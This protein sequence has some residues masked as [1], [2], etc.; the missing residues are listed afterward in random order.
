VRKLACI[1]AVAIVALLAL[2]AL[3]HKRNKRGFGRGASIAVA[4]GG[5]GDSGPQY[6]AR[7]GDDA[8]T[9]YWQAPDEAAWTL[10][11]PVTV[12]AHVWLDATSPSN[13]AVSTWGS[14]P[15]DWSW[16]YETATCVGAACP[17]RFRTAIAASDDGSGC[18]ATGTALTAITAGEW[19]TVCVVSDPSTDVTTFY[20]DG[21]GTS[22]VG[23]N[24]GTCALASFRDSA[25]L[26]HVG[27]WHTLGRYWRGYIRTVSVWDEAL[28]TTELDCVHSTAPSGSVG[29]CADTTPLL[30]VTGSATAHTTWTVN[31]A[32]S[33][34]DLSGVLY[35]QADFCVEYP[36]LAAGTCPAPTIDAVVLTGP[37]YFH[38][39][40]GSAQAVVW[41]DAG[42]KNDAGF[43][44]AYQTLDGGVVSAVDNSVGAAASIGAIQVAASSTGRPFILVDWQQPQ[45]ATWETDVAA[46]QT[47]LTAAAE[48]AR[49]RGLLLCPVG[50]WDVTGGYYQGSAGLPFLDGGTSYAPDAGSYLEILR[51]ITDT[52][53]AQIAG[54]TDGGGVD[55]A[56]ASLVLYDLKGP[57]PGTTTALVQAPYSADFY[58]YTTT[59]PLLDT[60]GW[61]VQSDGLHFDRV[62]HQQ[63]ADGLARTWVRASADTTAT[64]FVPT[65]ATVVDGETVAV[66]FS[67]PC[68]SHGDCATD[69]PLSVDVAGRVPQQTQGGVVSHGLHFWYGGSLAAPPNA[70]ATATPQACASP[71][72]SCTVNYV[73]TGGLP[74]FDELSFGDVY[75]KVF[76][77]SDCS[78]GPAAIYSG[79]SNLVSRVT[80]ACKTLPDGGTD[81]YEQPGYNRLSATY[82]A[83]VPVDAGFAASN[84]QYLAA[85]SGNY[86]TAANQGGGTA[87]CI[88]AWGD[89]PTANLDTIV[90][91]NT[92]QRGFVG[93][94]GGTWGCAI[95]GSGTPTYRVAS[96]T[97]STG[98]RY[99]VACCYAG[100]GAGPTGIGVFVGGADVSSTTNGSA[101]ALEADGL[102]NFPDSAATTDVDEVVV[103]PGKT[104]LTAGELL[105]LRCAT[106]AATDS[107]PTA[108]ECTGV[109]T[110]ISAI[111]A[112]AT[113]TRWYG[114]EGDATDRCGVLNGSA[115]GT[116]PY[117][118][119]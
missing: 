83:G 21:S 72:T 103:M 39:G 36:G 58:D 108:G 14:Y 57:Y 107:S 52:L 81:C 113:G 2:G 74:S 29:G 97:Y 3:P 40:G 76:G 1:A 89:L 77:N 42:V 43:T 111:C 46:L 87:Q 91:P 24:V 70:L 4:D 17:Q 34:G 71:A 56:C 12:C 104:T 114:F 68:R 41:T 90:Q 118:S 62:G 105:Q 45:T 8:I 9:E 35:E 82:D 22:E 32:G 25:G 85:T 92:N 86:V 99:D 119:Y 88:F 28:D 94:I 18:S 79:G 69:P 19:H 78:F 33:G 48:W 30:D 60:S 50:H 49:S 95:S 102:T 63:A 51:G 5:V 116:P 100:G 67:V 106:K 61:F 55:P 27:S 26:M 96:G 64:R 16:G 73:F 80:S 93:N 13:R 59:S 31:N 65:S 112:L 75:C 44:L 84:L 53:S 23:A 11:G 115:V 10:T 7:F 66:T 101:T 37:S 117:T 110:D 98:S 6:A 109:V 54:M 47:N 15:A 20:L 38:S